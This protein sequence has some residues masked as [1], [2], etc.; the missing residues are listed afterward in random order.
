MPAFAQNET[1]LKQYFEGK[2]A[3]VRADLPAAPQGIDIE[4]KQRGSARGLNYT[5]YAKRLIKFGPAVREGQPAKIRELRVFEKHIEIYVGHSRPGG[6]HARAR[7]NLK[8]GGPLPAEA[9]TPDGVMKAL[10]KVVEFPDEKARLRAESSYGAIRIGM[11]KASVEKL[12][13]APSI[14]SETKED[15]SAVLNCRY[16]LPTVRIK[17]RFV[18]DTLSVYTTERKND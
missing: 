6:D 13:G 5:K 9:L 8:Y 3:I 12:I 1:A 14:C 16:N 18:E 15:G 2:V 11:K 4:V 7:I 10:L 17:A